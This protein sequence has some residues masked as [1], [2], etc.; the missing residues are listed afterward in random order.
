MN[1]DDDARDE[2]AAYN[3]Q[4]IDDSDLKG[5]RFEAETKYKHGDYEKFLNRKLKSV[6]YVIK[7]HYD[8]LRK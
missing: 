8:F 4:K 7:K 1:Y 2:S 6:H 3:S 5:A